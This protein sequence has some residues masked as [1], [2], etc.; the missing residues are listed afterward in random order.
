MYLISHG[1]YSIHCQK[2]L[3]HEGLSTTPYFIQG[4]TC[5]SHSDWRGLLD[6]FRD[7]QKILFENAERSPQYT[8]KTDDIVIGV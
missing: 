2:K 6:D 7:F 5:K 1:D 8:V 3:I 4:E